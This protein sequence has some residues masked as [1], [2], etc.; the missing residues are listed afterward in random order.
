MNWI[1]QYLSSV[2]LCE[3]E[4]LL[5]LIIYRPLAFLFV[6]C[7]CKS[8]LT[9]NNTTLIGIAFGMTAGFCFSL[10]SPL[11]NLIGSIFLLIY[12]V[13]DCADGMIA[14]LKNN[15]TFFG[16]I[17]DGIADYTVGIAVYIG[18]GVSYMETSSTP[19]VH[20]GM[21][22]LVGMSN[23]M[24]SISLD[25]YRTKYR[26]YAFNRDLT[27]SASIAEFE[28]EREKLEALKG[29]YFSKFIIYVYIKYSKIQLNA[30]AKKGDKKKYDRDDYLKKNKRIVN[31]WT[32]IGPS[33]S[34][35][36]IIISALLNNFEIFI[37]GLLIVSN[38]Y[39]ILL[40]I[41]Q[42]QINKRIIV[43]KKPKN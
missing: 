28:N 5:D 41:I 34:L 24:H 26:D 7:V 33:S 13:L 17:L 29:S 37:W 12:I 22:L 40:F 18:I 20:L 4:E 1:K 10:S 8:R 15:G 42:N 30:Y 14:R 2:K 43:L 25:F 23:I 36:L 38:T 39:A 27:L 9:P 3:V 6:K 21:L 16:R 11:T 35:T 32:Y 31:F 19:L